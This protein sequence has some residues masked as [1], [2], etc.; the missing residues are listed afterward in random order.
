MGRVSPSNQNKSGEKKSR[1]PYVPP[2]PPKSPSSRYSAGNAGGPGQFDLGSIQV[3]TVENRSAGSDNRR[4]SGV[5]GRGG[6][7][8]GGL[9]PSPN[10]GRRTRY[11]SG[12]AVAGAA[13]GAAADTSSGSSAL[14]SLGR[15]D[16]IPAAQYPEGVSTG[17]GGGNAGGYVPPTPRNTSGVAPDVRVNANGVVQKGTN[18]DSMASGLFND[19]ASRYENDGYSTPETVALIKGMGEGTSFSSNRLPATADSL[20]TDTQGAV[21]AFEK[22]DLAINTGAKQNTDVN[23]G[24]ETPDSVQFK[25]PNAEL[26]N[27]TTEAGVKKPVEYTN[28][29]RNTK[30]DSADAL[31]MNEMQ[32]G[33]IYASGQYWAKGAD[34]NAVKVD[35]NLAKGV[36]RGAE[37]AASQLAAYLKNG[38]SKP[39]DGGFELANT[40]IPTSEADKPSQQEF[41]P[42]DQVEFT[43]PDKDQETFSKQYPNMFGKV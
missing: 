2:A 32:H 27:I 33:L 26:T 42:S 8:L 35:R 7:D 11:S 41:A 22:P 6:V 10:T 15:Y 28:H 31:R 17:V 36:K 3:P 24:F 34:G 38:G 18:F 29:M 30:I 43:K 21:D 5:R 14:A 16:D 12:A 9:K 4:G 19:I 37:G 1:S 20:Y 13:A 25:E 23:V 40:D 39:E